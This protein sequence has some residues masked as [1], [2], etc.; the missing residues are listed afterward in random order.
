MAGLWRFQNAYFTYVTPELFG[1]KEFFTL[2][3]GWQKPDGYLRQSAAEQILHQ[4]HLHLESRFWRQQLRLG[5]QLA[6]WGGYAK[7][8]PNDWFYAQSGLYMAVPKL[9]HAGKP[10][11]VFCRCASRRTPM[12]FTGFPETG[13]TPKIGPSKLP[14]RYAT[15]MSSIRV[16][17]T[18]PYYGAN[19]DQRVI[20]YWQADQMLFR[21]PSPEAAPS[22]RDRPMAK[23]VAG[24]KSFKEP[25]K[26]EEKAQRPGSA[27]SLASINFAPKFNNP[28]RSTSTPASSARV[29]FRPAT[30]INSVS[31]FAYRRLTATTSSCPMSV[32]DAPSR[33][34]EAV[35]EFSYRI[36]VNKW[37]YVQP[38][39]QY[40]IRAGRDRARSR[41]PP[42]W[43]SN[44][45]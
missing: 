27:I 39:L 42:F 31:A 28:G 35:V 38:D 29:S 10:R 33:P 13:V 20:F 41:M 5:R 1:I 21:E 32:A 44:M 7:V 11:P 26:V 25:V 2:S 37:A 6:S 40:I 4:Q 36:Q 12:A 16:W 30:R 24:G 45:V 14:G 18:R 17:Q 8:K 15:G 34:T 19:S 3:G 23:S 43:A 22:P 9:Q